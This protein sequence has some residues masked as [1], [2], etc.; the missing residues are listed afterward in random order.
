MRRSATANKTRIDNRVHV[1]FV[2]ASSPIGFQVVHEHDRVVQR[3]DG[4]FSRWYQHATAVAVDGDL[5]FVKP[6]RH[7]CGTAQNSKNSNQ[8][9]NLVGQQRETAPRKARPEWL[10]QVFQPAPATTTTTTTVTRAATPAS[11]VAASSTKKETAS[12]M[13]SPRQEE[14]RKDMPDCQPSRPKRQLRRQAN[15]AAVVVSSDASNTHAT[16]EITE[17]ED[18]DGDFDDFDDDISDM[19]P[20]DYSKAYIYC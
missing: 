19:T 14:Q 10:T 11:T 12:I 16:E 6:T 18:D 15:C 5:P 1:P 7:A 9:E 13:L 20:E 17:Y 2:V 8:E 3:Q 4:N